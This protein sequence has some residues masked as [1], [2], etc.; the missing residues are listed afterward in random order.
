LISDEQRNFGNF[1][2]G[3]LGRGLKGFSTAI[4]GTIFKNTSLLLALHT[5]I[6]HLNFFPEFH[7]FTPSFT[8]FFGC[9]ILI[10]SE[11]NN[12]NQ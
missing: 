6:G 8:L 10:F 7:V 5:K 9:E 1:K 11:N 4:L 2:Y 3:I 12:K